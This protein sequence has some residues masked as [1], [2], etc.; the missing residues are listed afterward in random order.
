MIN[1]LILKPNQVGTIKETLETWKYARVKLPFI[2][3][4]HRSG[5]T[6]SSFISDFA[7]GISS[8][9]VKFGAP[10]RGERTAK[11]NRLMEIQDMI[12][13]W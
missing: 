8:P 4:S 1:G 7:V 13:G 2:V 9:Y 6:E 3:T 5:E 10:A 11:Y 12:R